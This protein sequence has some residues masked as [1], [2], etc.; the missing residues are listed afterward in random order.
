MEEKKNRIIN[1]TIAVFL[2]IVDFYL[3]THYYR[4]FDRPSYQPADPVCLY[5]S[6]MYCTGVL[7]TILIDKKDRLVYKIL[8]IL[9]LFNLVTLFCIFTWFPFVPWLLANDIFRTGL[10]GLGNY[11][12]TVLW[13]TV[14]YGKKIIVSGLPINKGSYEIKNKWKDLKKNCK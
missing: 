7:T 4:W 14:A 12:Y 5:I 10:F 11:T 1:M 2:L 13:L 9:L 8:R 6:L 3:Y